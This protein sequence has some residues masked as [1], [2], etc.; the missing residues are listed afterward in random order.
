VGHP[1]DTIHPSTRTYKRLRKESEPKLAGTLPW[2]KLSPTSLRVENS[3]RGRAYHTHEEVRIAWH[4][5]VLWVTIA[6]TIA[7]PCGT[8]QAED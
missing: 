6:T 1:H 7:T 8:K 5:C 4:V 2:M 3:S